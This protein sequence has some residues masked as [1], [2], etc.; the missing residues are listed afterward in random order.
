MRGA[1]WEEKRLTS[2]NGCQAGVAVAK[3][4][5]VQQQV[6]KCQW[7]SCTYT[8]RH[9]HTQRLQQVHM[10]RRQSAPSTAVWPVPMDRRPAISG[11]WDAAPRNTSMVTKLALGSGMQQYTWT[12]YLCQMQPP[13]I[14]KNNLIWIDTVENLTV[15]ADWINL[16]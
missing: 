15:S 9:A 10:P 8:N 5:P 14:I 7:S 1:E 4:M 2:I 13:T 16:F 12:V 6:Y 11:I 3:A